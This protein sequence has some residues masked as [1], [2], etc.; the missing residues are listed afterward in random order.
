[1]DGKGVARARALEGVEISVLEEDGGWGS[2]AASGLPKLRLAK[3]KWGVSKR[4]TMGC[5]LLK[6][7]RGSYNGLH[8]AADWR[9]GVNDSVLLLLAEFAG[10]GCLCPEADGQV[11]DAACSVC[12]GEICLID[13]GR[14]AR[15]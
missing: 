10:E 5:V 13:E 3:N 14:E 2:G 8:L 1:M 9:R 11:C 4:G 12:D 6:L 15:A 7:R